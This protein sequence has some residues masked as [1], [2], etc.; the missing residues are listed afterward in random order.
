MATV[1][2][3]GSL[4]MDLLVLTPRLP[5]RGENLPRTD[6]PWARA[7]RAP[8]RRWPHGVVEALLGES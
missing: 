7:G 4:V 8:T 3:V 1:A 5:A 6:C 2:V